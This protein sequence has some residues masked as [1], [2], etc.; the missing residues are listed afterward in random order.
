MYACEF[1]Q[2]TG[3]VVELRLTTLGLTA[4]SA[5]GACSHIAA[6]SWQDL[7]QSG[8]LAKLLAQAIR[9]AGKQAQ[10]ATAPD[11]QILAA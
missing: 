2:A 4:F 9:R 5:D 10:T 7:A 6:V 1:R 11:V 3:V 8:D